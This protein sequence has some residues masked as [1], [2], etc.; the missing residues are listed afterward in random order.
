MRKVNSIEEYI[1]R[2]EKWSDAL[3]Q[4]HEL[5]VSAG[6]QGSIKWNSPVY[7]L[8][9]KNILGLGAFKKHFAIWFFQGV[10]LSDKD[11]VLVNA[12]EGTTK[13]LRQMRFNSPDEIDK[14]T[15]L[16]YTLEAIENQKEGRELKSGKNKVV[17]PVE[18]LEAFKQD[19]EIE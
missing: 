3:I 7:N 6:L 1:I 17:I 10:F 9:G 18:L 4:L 13:A 5:I 16:S 12:Q 11:K 19:K 8:G 15:I 14:E 2:N